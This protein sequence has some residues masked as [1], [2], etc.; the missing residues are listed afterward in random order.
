MGNN[1]NIITGYYQGDNKM[2]SGFEKDKF[3]EIWY[4]NTRKFTD[5]KIYVINI[6]GIFKKEDYENVEFINLDYNL[7]HIGQL[8]KTKK[9]YLSGWTLSILIG[10]LICYNNNVDFLYKEQDCL[11]FGDINDVYKELE[12]K[13]CKS[14][15]QILQRGWI[16]QSFFIVKHE[17]IL[18]FVTEWLNIPYA[19][20]QMV[21]EKKHNMIYITHPSD[22]RPFDF[23][24]GRNRPFN[25]KDKTFFIQQPK[26]EELDMLKQNN[27][28]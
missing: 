17:F 18:T 26:I 16:E 28:I 12:D 22:I 4:K 19:D 14:L 5:N 27:L 21:T 23:G 10:L 13:K 25:I 15:I 20:Y 7:G 11:F 2:Y 8:I 9:F 3:F 6:D 1:F 24:Y